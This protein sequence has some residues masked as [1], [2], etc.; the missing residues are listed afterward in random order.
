M[1]DLLIC[2]ATPFE[3]ELLRGRAELLVTG[4]GAVNA[5]CALTRYLE[6][7]DVKR[8]L[9]CGIGGAYRNSG[10]NIGDVACAASECYGDLG[11][12]SPE[13]FLDLEKLGF[14]LLPGPLYNRLELQIFPHPRQVPFVTV[15][16]CTGLD[17]LSDAMEARTGGAIENMEGAALVHAARLYNVP[18]GE[19]RAISNR[20]GNRDRGTWRIKE[21]A[22]AAQR[23]VLT[24]LGAPNPPRD[25]K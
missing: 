14:P 2:T 10:L 11:A 19:I 6:R 13:G 4:V 5:A 17:T 3:S 8:V 12:E 24:W 21:A 1:I 16:T 22:E 23:A 15:N 9:V 25:G 20:T 7:H 18:V